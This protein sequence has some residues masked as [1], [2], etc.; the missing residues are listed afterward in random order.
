MLH[1]PFVVFAIP[2]FS[3]HVC[4][5]FCGS[6]ART[7]GLLYHANID[8]ALHFRGGIA[9]IDAVRNILCAEFLR[10][11]PSATDLFFLDDDIGWQPEKV[12]EFLRRPEEVVAGVYPKRS[13]DVEFPTVLRIDQATRQPIEQNGLCAAAMV[14][15]G[16]LRLK[17]SAV[18]KL[19][20]ASGSYQFPDKN[21]LDL[22]VPNIFEVG[23]REGVYWGEDTH[24]VEK[25]A[26]LGGDIW[27]DPNIV[28]TH[29]GNKKWQGRLLESVQHYIAHGPRKELAPEPELELLE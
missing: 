28:F 8:H 22:V 2:T 11:F 5:D 4:V 26:G 9:F 1:K 18:E 21:M 16:F 6:M 27:V 19:A 7:V 10:D 25:W 13:D 20:A 12:L 23:P 29:R 15:A 17:R 24:F 14:P 3:H